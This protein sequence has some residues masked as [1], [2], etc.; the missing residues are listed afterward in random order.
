[1]KLILEELA[2]RHNRRG[3]S[4]GV[5][6]LD[7]YIGKTALQHAQKGISRT[8]VLVPEENRTVIIGYYTLTPCQIRIDSLRE[9]HGKTKPKDH[10]IPAC[11]LARLAVATE[12]Q[13][14]GLG[15][16]LLVHAME[17]YLQAQ[18]LIGMCALFVD[19]KDE[20][21]ARFY[22]KFGFVRSC[23]DPLQLYLPTETIREAFA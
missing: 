11:K 17:H 22:E 5:Q 3:F 10:P 4:C 7:Y 9:E 15:T 16:K 2:R 6:P 13:K 1:M 8:F 19:A 12:W 14:K 21:A 18:S 20:N 23:D